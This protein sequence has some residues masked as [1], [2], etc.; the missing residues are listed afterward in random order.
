[1]ELKKSLIYDSWTGPSDG[2][3]AGVSHNS[4]K[5]RENSIFVAISGY[6]ADGHDYIS[7]A[8]Q[9]GARVIVSEKYVQL[10][11]GITSI[12]TKDSR[13]AL[14]EIASIFYGHPSKDLTITGITGTNGKTSTSLLLES[15]LKAAGFETGVIGTIGYRYKGHFLPALNTTPDALEFQKLLRMMADDGV[16]HV[17]M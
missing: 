10:P 5:I 4:L 7:D 17:V 13:V 12:I 2:E 3:V 16:T 1:M 11:F 9:K 14:A 8:L 15:I 6:N